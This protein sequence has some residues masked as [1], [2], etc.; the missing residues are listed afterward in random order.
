MGSVTTVNLRNLP[1]ELVRRA[2]QRAEKRGMTLKGLMIMALATFLEN[3]PPLK[4]PEWVNQSEKPPEPENPDRVAWK[5]HEMYGRYPSP[6]E[7]EH[8]VRKGW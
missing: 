8:F 5:Y 3:N 2:K 1:P 4:M 6:S 7:R